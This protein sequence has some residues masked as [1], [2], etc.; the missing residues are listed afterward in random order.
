MSLLAVLIVVAVRCCSSFAQTDAEIDAAMRDVQRYLSQPQ[1]RTSTG[2]M[3]EALPNSNKIFLGYNPIY[4]SPTCF[5]GDCQMEGFARAVFKSNYQKRPTG[6][7]TTKLIPEHVDLDCLP[8]IAS[9]TSTEIIDSLDKLQQTVMQGIDVSAS[10]GYKGVSFSYAFSRQTR[11]MVDTIVRENST[12]LFTT[13]KISCYKLSSFSPAM[14]LS[15]AFRRVI[16]RMP[17]CNYS[18][19]LERYIFEYIFNYFGFTYVKD[20]LLGGVMQQKIT[21]NEQERTQ[22]TKNDVSTSHSA[23]LQ[24]A[25]ASFSASVGVKLSQGVEQEKMNTFRKYSKQSSVMALGGDSSILTVEEWSKTVPSNPVI[26]KFGI[27]PILELLDEDK[28]PEDRNITVKAALIERALNHYIDRPVFC[29]RNCTRG[30]CKPS[31]YF[32]FGM[33]ECPV[34]FTGADCSIRP[35]PKSAV[36]SGTLCGFTVPLVGEIPCG[37]LTNASACV[38]GYVAQRNFISPFGGT[39][40]RFLGSCFKME[41]A[42]EFSP[43]GTL[44]G[45][46]TNAPRRPLNIHCNGRHPYNHACPPGY[47]QHSLGSW[48]TCVKTDPYQE[49]LP[50]TLCGMHAH[51]EY[52]YRFEWYANYKCNGYNIN[53]GHCPPGY[54]FVSGFSSEYYVQSIWDIHPAIRGLYDRSNIVQVILLN[55]CVKS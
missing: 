25:A 23:L 55:F 50:G 51:I 40:D 16:T 38:P 45:F 21:I 34:G 28:F 8:S 12:V 44:C 1:P 41:E 35:T 18:A 6:S 47:K 42:L 49:D 9:T 29:Y 39:V 13:S 2:N 53:D 36:P 4:G 17:C 3:E 22:M 48:A 5:S 15:D 43:V 7:C 52:N 10:V 27:S 19:K 33:C 26:I 11:N 20:I 31:G 37:N 46:T 30:V 32:Q 14:E 54:S 24:F